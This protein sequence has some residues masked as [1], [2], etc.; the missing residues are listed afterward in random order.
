MTRRVWRARA[1]FLVLVTLLTAAP[2]AAE[3]P[4]AASRLVFVLLPDHADL[5][6]AATR[7]LAAHFASS[8]TT[9]TVLEGARAPSLRAQADAVA[10]IVAAHGAAGGFWLDGA[11]RDE[12]HLYFVES[13]A[14][15][16]LVRRIPWAEA[17]TVGEQVALMASFTALAVARGEHI[18]MQPVVLPE[19]SPPPT[20]LAPP[21]PFVV[22]LPA[23]MVARPRSRPPRDPGAG[24]PTIEI[25]ASYVGASYSPA[26][27]FMHGLRLA[28]GY[29]FARHWSAELGVLVFPSRELAVEDARLSTTSLRW[30]LGLGYARGV[31]PLR[32]GGRLRLGGGYRT[33]RTLALPSGVQA[34]ADSQVAEGAVALLGTASLPLWRWLSVDAAVG[35]ELATVNQV[36]VTTAGEARVL[37]ESGPVRLRVEGG[38]R[39]AF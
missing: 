21:P 8:A 26:L 38:L 6:Q 12:V 13:A 36:A 3:E 22:P 28:V 14:T 15:R 33:R 30:E 5:N 37:D 35:P 9:L 31:G 27:P 39:F 32:I 19:P 23:P 17:T 11:D 4:A 34:T 1:V 29:A 25:A 7:A 10:R 24:L 18:G 20:A 2:V 16:I